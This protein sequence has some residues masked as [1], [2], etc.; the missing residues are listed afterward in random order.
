[1]SISRSQA[2]IDAPIQ[3]VW[4]LVADVERHPDWWPNVIE[5]EC[6]DIEQGCTYRRVFKRPFGVDDTTILIDELDSYR[7]LKIRC[8]DTGSFASFRLAESQGGTFVDAEAGLEAKTAATKIFD[9]LGGKRFYSRWLDQSLD[10]L[11]AAACERA[12]AEPSPNA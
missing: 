7:A 2:Q 12:T 4:R 5:V 6:G 9:R 10:A 8:L 1:M 3:T 11:R